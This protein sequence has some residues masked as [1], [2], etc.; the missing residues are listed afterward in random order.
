M[1]FLAWFTRARHCTSSTRR[2][3]ACRNNP[4]SLWSDAAAALS[5]DMAASHAEIESL[6]QSERH[7]LASHIG[8]VI[9]HLLKLEVSPSTDPARLRDT[10]RR[11]RRDIAGL[12]RDSPSLQRKIPRM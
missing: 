10:I 5:G 3:R 4:S 2:P 9:E 11:A 12:L 6:G 1:P 7:A 8:T